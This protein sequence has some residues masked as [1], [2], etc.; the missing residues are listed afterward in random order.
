MS[1]RSYLT[2]RD[3]ESLDE[4]ALLRELLQAEV[5]DADALGQHHLPETIVVSQHRQLLSSNPNHDNNT[6]F[7]AAT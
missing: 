6:E 7:I 4:A 1:R 5:S 3:V 2:V